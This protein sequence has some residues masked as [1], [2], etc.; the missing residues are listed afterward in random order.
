M[1]PYLYYIYNLVRRKGLQQFYI[2]LQTTEL[3]SN[4]YNSKTVAQLI[5]YLI[6]KIIKV[7]MIVGLCG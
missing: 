1:L 6:S 4:F 3:T 2:Y 7:C 5:N